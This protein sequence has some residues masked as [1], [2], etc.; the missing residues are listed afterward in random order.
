MPS[1]L[2]LDQGTTG[3]T[4]LVIHQDGSVLGRGYREFTQYFP[5]PG[6][7]EH[8]PE[9]IFRVSLEAIGEALAG[10]RERPAGI[11]IT[12]QRETVVLWDRRS[13]A[14]VGPAIVWQDRRTS[15][16]CRELR[17]SGTEQLLRARTGLV[18]DPYFSATKLEWMLSD[19][20]IRR[21]AA[22]G[23]LAAGTVESWL[24]ARL[25][26][27]RVH[28]S[29]HTNASRT[30]LYD[31]AER[32]WHPELLGIFGVPRE[33]L[34]S[35]VPSSGV[36]GESDP[37]HFGFSLPIAGLA[38][39]QQ[40]ALFGQGCCTD[41]L[42][43]NTYGT[44]AFLLV[45]RGDR[46]PQP[47]N[48]VLATAACGPKGEPAYALEGSVFIAGA[49]VQWLRDGL[50]IIAT[51]PETDAL[52]RSVPDTGGVS[53]VP[54]FVG[55]GTPHWEPEA[56]GTIT[57]ITRGTTRAHLVRAALEAIAFSSAE[58]L[59]AMAG[60]GLRVPALRVDGGAAANDWLMQCQ[61]DVLGIPVE[62]P[63]MVETT[64]L[65]A[66]G[67][68]GLALGVWRGTGDFLAGR[69]FRRFEPAT[70]PG[71]RQRRSAEWE[72]AVSAALA[73]AGGRKKNNPGVNPGY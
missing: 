38:G 56:R 59:A 47:P 1:I 15:P 68:A 5:R 16:R 4:A 17:D 8:D 18:A 26:G 43:K 24:V 23:R 55:L 34:P 31:L 25:T 66:A 11:G 46:L 49:A 70:D 27:G 19:P 44:G 2:A 54:A 73:W 65:G 50:G 33:V 37:A 52:A 29:D 58:L 9:E 36:V 62:R 53:F 48:G 41:G 10:S 39:D 69:R 30:L 12:N 20:A 71:E 51:A 22:A 32:D 3:S 57:G 40:S 42:A 60:S 61:A 21:R 28:A 63:D 6:W 13:L 14:P 67:L 45:H 72:R 64:A 7:V 35:I